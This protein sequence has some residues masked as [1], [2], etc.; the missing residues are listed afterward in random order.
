LKFGCICIFKHTSQDK[1]KVNQFEERVLL[2]E[3]E[4]YEKAEEKFLDEFQ[5]YESD[6][7]IFLNEYEIFEI[8]EIDKP[9]IEVA[10]SMKVFTGT[11]DEYLDKYFYDQKPLS[12][13][14]VGWQHS[15]YNVDGKRS[16]CYNCQEI[17]NEKLW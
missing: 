5:E 13:D 9:V 6:E 12:C 11:D 2:T 15:W 10:S 14:N 1:N 8:N 7:C 3:A 16:A 17:R 4:T